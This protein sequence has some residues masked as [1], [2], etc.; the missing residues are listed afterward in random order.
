VADAP[1]GL[2]REHDVVEVVALGLLVDAL[3]LRM[4]QAIWR[5]AKEDIIHGCLGLDLEQQAELDAVIDLYSWELDLV[6]GAEE[7]HA[8]THALAPFPRLRVVLPLADT[9][10]EARRGFWVRA[11]PTTELAR[12]K[13]RRGRGRA[14]SK[15]AS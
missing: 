12:D 6:H 7:L 14:G 2:Y 5:G 13:R 9:V 4:T 1:D 3:G 11:A 10:R 15:R 8:A